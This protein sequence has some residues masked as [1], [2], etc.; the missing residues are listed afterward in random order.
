MSET[1]CGSGAGLCLLNQESAKEEGPARYAGGFGQ[2]DV[3]ISSPLNEKSP[4]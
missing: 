4:R 3:I 2:D 1:V